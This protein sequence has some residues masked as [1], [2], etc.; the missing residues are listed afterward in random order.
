[1][2]PKGRRILFLEK[3]LDRME[4]YNNLKQAEML[5]E[6]GNLYSRS[7]RF[8]N[9]SE[10]A[11]NYWIAANIYKKF[12][13]KDKADKYFFKACRLF[14]KCGAKWSLADIRRDRKLGLL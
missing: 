5:I 3:E 11:Y 6:L 13:K 7:G 10:A 12:L 1:M 14:I 2:T 4:D 8:F 9:L